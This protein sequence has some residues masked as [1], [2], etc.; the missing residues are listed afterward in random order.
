MGSTDSASR[1]QRAYAH[2]RPEWDYRTGL[3][4]GELHEFRQRWRD[5]EDQIAAFQ[6]AKKEMLAAVRLRHGRHEAEAIKLTMRV[7]AMEPLKRA[8]HFH[9]NDA[10]RRYAELLDGEDLEGNDWGHMADDN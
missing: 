6:N 9:F 8:E 4:T 3:T 10:A 7:M 2:A 1:A 5:C